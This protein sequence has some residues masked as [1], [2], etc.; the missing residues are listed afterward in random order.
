MFTMPAKWLHNMIL[1][2]FEFRMILAWF[3]IFFKYNYDF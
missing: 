1:T 3:L 2:I